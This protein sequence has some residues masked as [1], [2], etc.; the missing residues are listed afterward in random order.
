MTKNKTAA[1]YSGGG[2]L[3]NRDEGSYDELMT[4]AEI[5]LPS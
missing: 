2:L 4:A 3:R 5:F 1:A